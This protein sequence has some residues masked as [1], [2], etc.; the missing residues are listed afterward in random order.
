MMQTK[1][2]EKPIIFSSD[3][4]CAIEDGLKT[5]TRRIVTPQPASNWSIPPALLDQGFLNEYGC[6]R[7]SDSIKCPWEQE[8]VLWVREKWHHDG[9]GGFLY[10]ADNPD[11]AEPYENQ[12]WRNPMFMPKAACRLW[13]QIQA[14]DI[15]RVRDISEEDSIAEGFLSEGE[16]SLSA[17]CKFMHAWDKLNDK[18]GFDWKSNPWVWV[19]RFQVHQS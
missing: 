12:S 17:Q 9:R 19:I 16:F 14:V 10:A 5:Q 18:R 7:D 1:T 6:H 2:K 8:D 15:Q 13:L 11:F 4:I 3:S